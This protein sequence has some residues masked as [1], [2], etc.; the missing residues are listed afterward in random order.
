MIIKNAKVFNEN[1]EF[2]EKDIFIN[3]ELFSQISD[4][5]EILSA[6]NL[7]MIPGLI[8]VHFHGCD[9]YDF[10]DGT[11][12]AVQAIANYE[13]KNGIT[14]LVPATMTFSKDKL[15]E[16]MKNA[17]NYKSNIGS[18]V[19]GINM[20]GPFISPQKK[21]AQNP[22]YIHR[23][24]ILFY[25][26]LQNASGNLI[27]LVDIAPEMENAMSFIKEVKDEVNISVAH[28]TADY[29]IASE[30]F[31]NG[32]SHVTHLFNA[33]PAFSH[34]EPG[35]VGAALDNNAYV[36]LI[37]DNVHIHP[38]VVR[39]TFKMFGADKVV[40]V[41]DSMM[42]T[43]LKDGEYYL[44]GQL[45]TV[46]GNKAT[47]F[48]GTIAGSATNLMDCMKTAIKVMNITICDA[49]RAATINPAKAV[50]IDDKYGSISEGKIAN[51]VLLDNDLNIHSVYIA[52]KKF[53]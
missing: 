1:F 9:G 43:G 51:F 47:L 49:V 25:K 24:D 6:D 33:M 13:G 26:D 52:G 29:D 28:T 35:V 50:G 20:E 16:V 4:N 30:A 45:V 44:G 10:C 8:D 37:C 15:L 11:Y 40:L 12:E 14:T 5:E 17:A 34:R 38:S 46:T 21:G 41:S 32:A 53:I 18:Q 7:Y 23:P 27:K 22:K 3:G 2:E 36:E 42:A 39:A 19:V 48:D 31:I